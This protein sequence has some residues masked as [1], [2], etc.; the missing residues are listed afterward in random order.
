MF[1]YFY[2]SRMDNQN[3]AQDHTDIQWHKP[4]VFYDNMQTLQ[5]DA[6]F[7]PQSTC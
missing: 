5:L 3:H 7:S 2:A 1:N 6:A 4:Q